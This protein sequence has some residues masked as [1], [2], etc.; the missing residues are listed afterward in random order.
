VNIAR[1]AVFPDWPDHK[2]KPGKNTL[3]NGKIINFTI[4]DEIKRQQSDAPNKIIYLQQVRHEDGRI[5]LRLCY[6]IIGKLPKMKGRWVFG[7][8]ATFLPA[9]DFKAIIDQAKKRG[10]I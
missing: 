9:K 1:K 4:L 7:Q 6:Y 2:G 5:E 3:P 10:W 8:F